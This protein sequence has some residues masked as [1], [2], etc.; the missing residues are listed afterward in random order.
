[1]HTRTITPTAVMNRIHG[2]FGASRTQRVFQRLHGLALVGLNYGEGDPE[3]NGEYRLLERLAA[4]WP[5]QPVVFDVG[6]ASG[7]WSSALLERAPAARVHA[8]E[9]RVSEH[10]SIQAAGSGIAVHGFALGD[11]EG[12]ATLVGTGELSSLHRR[13]LR[14]FGTT[15]VGPELGVDVVRLDRF[16]SEQG[17]DHIHLLKIDAEGHDLAVLRGA[18][19]LLT[20]TRITAIQFEFGGANIDSRTFMRDFRRLLEP[21]GYRIERV[22]RDGSVPIEP[23]E[24]AEIFTYGNFIAV[25][26]G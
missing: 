25:P 8:F 20:P 24:T 10:A 7:A 12:P 15:D 14:D 11:V 22:L 17:I 13:D 19:E 3:R 18:G 21:L 5:S 23:V 1:M 26:H 4:T 6:A 2:V 9:P 16:C